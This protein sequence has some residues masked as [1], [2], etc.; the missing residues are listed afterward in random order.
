VT[1]NFLG[2]CKRNAYLWIGTVLK[3]QRMTWI[4]SA[5][6]VNEFYLRSLTEQWVILGQLFHTSLTTSNYVFLL[7]MVVPILGMKH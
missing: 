5:C 2:R 3:A 1:L 4:R 6:H 7:P